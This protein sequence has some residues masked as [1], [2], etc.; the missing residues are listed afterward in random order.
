MRIL[1][2]RHGEKSGNGKTC[3]LTPLGREMARSAGMWMRR[4]GLLPTAAVT[5]EYLRTQETAELAC[6][7]AGVAPPTTPRDGLPVKAEGWAILLTELRT[8][9][10]AEQDLVLLVGHH[11]TQGM[12]ESAKVLAPGVGAIPKSNRA[13]AYLVEQDNKGEWKVTRKY[14]GT[15][16]ASAGD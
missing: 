4:E 12:F 15:P 2:L 8:R 6:A 3:P 5:T 1:F 10:P 16:T 14:N 13:G 7:A 9:A 11:G